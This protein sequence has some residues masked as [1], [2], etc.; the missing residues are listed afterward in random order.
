MFN[1][2][3]NFV[4][5]IG[6]YGEGRGEFNGQ[7]DVKFDAAGNMYVAE[8]TNRRIQVLDSSSNYIRVFGEGKLC[9]PSGLYIADK[10]VY[11]S[12]H[13]SHCVLVGKNGE[14]EGEFD[15]LFCITSSVDGFLY[16][17]DAWNNRVQIF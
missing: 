5:T 13:A 16:V 3:L 12:D 6:S 17:C 4:Q 9:E 7:L 8:L 1:L 11:V 14:N 10:Y 2:D 15:G